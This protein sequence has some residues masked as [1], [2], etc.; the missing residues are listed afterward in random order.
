MGT[1]RAGVTSARR[2]TAAAR[3]SLREVSFAK[4]VIQLR[5]TK[6]TARGYEVLVVFGAFI[7]VKHRHMMCSVSPHRPLHTARLSRIPAARD[8]GKENMAAYQT[9][10][11]GENAFSFSVNLYE[12]TLE[13]P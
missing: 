12:V 4:V 2:N 6:N 8:A 9:V 11:N 1:T 10:F 7:I 13:K 5:I 3:F